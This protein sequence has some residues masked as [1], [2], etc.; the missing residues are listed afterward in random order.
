MYFIIRNNRFQRKLSQ[1]E[2]FKRTSILKKTYPTH[3]K[4]KKQKN[5]YTRASAP[6]KPNKE[7]KV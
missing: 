7:L 2:V 4:P 5:S 1:L 6:N 3:N